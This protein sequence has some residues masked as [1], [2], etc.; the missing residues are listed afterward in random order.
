MDTPTKTRL[1]LALQIALDY[2][3]GSEAN[4]EGM[5]VLAGKLATQ[6]CDGAAD[7]STAYGVDPKTI[8]DLWELAMEVGDLVR[9]FDKR[10][11]ELVLDFIEKPD[12]PRPDLAH[13]STAEMQAE[14]AKR[15]AGS[16]AT[17]LVNAAS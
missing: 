8:V 7:L 3:R 1:E 4:V 16:R 6:F 2:E 5:D 12:Q 14:I 9:G 11:K 15:S 10:V 17:D 13:V